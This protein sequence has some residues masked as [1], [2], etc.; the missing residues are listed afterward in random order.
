MRLHSDIITRTDIF[1]ALPRDVGAE[2]MEHGS[3]KRARA[4]EVSLSGL[5]ARH[6]RKKNSGQ[7]G[8]GYDYAATWD[9]WGLWLAALYEIDPDMHATY[10]KNRDDFYEQT[11]RRVPDGMV[12]PW[13]EATAA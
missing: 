8:A 9:D 4:F 7:Y 10:Y 5:G 2:V 12:A 1:A 6:T 13:L 11:R 3:R